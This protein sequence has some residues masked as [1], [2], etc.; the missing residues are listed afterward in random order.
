MPTKN[1]L[2][3]RTD[4]GNAEL[5]A[6]L[7][8][9][10][11]R[12]DYGQKRW[13]LYR[14]HW[15]TP[16]SD[17]ELMRMAKDTARFRFHNSA[18]IADEDIRKKEVEWALRS[19]NLQRLEAMITLAESEKPLADDGGNWDGN[20]FLLGVANGVV[21]LK[22]GTLRPGEPCDKI[23]LHTEVAFDPHA[24]CHRFDRF[25]EEIFDADADLISYI[26]RAVGYSLL[27]LLSWHGGQWQK[28]ASERPPT[29]DRRL[30]LQPAILGV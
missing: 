2:P 26:H 4:F 19:E 10:R 16:D 11:L 17:G 27:F 15:W 20:P 18:R 12:F 22:T 28:H 14:Q 8:G 1:W 13:L 5:L 7:F 3:R 21:D 25:L 23:T 6:A 29:C 24:K 30:R 9:E